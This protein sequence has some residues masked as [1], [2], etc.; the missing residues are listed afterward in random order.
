MERE[1]LPLYPLPHIEFYKID[2]DRTLLRAN[3]QLSPQQ[4]IEKLQ[5]ALRLVTELQAAGKRLRKLESR[6]EE[7]KEPAKGP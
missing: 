7:S 6:I 5:A 4:R 2:I 1:I 3:L